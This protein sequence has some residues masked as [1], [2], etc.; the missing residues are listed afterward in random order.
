MQNLRRVDKND[1]PI[2]SHLG[3]K[4]PEVSRRVE[5]PRSFRC[6][7]PIVYIMFLSEDI[8]H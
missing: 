1:G 7:C 4:V 3:A 2:L 6:L 5:D 8:R